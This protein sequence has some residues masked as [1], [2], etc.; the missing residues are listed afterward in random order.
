MFTTL[1]LGD[2]VLYNGVIYRIFGLDTS[3]GLYVIKLY[4]ARYNIF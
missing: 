3:N 4:G 2:N 1:R